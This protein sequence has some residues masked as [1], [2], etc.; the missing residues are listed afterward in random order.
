MASCPA[1]VDTRPSLSLKETPVGVVLLHDFGGCPTPKIVHAIGLRLAD[2]FPDDGGRRRERPVVRDDDPDLMHAIALNLAHDEAWGRRGVVESYE[3][4]DTFRWC[5][6]A[7]ARVRHHAT[8]L[9]DCAAAW[10][11]LGAAAQREAEL[12][13]VELDG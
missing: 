1:H 10:T 11:L 3:K 4:A 13:E 9:G 7:I 12:N 2:L 5:C 6:Q 8:T